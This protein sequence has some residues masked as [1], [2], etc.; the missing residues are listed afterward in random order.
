MK[1]LGISDG[2]TGGAALLE[3]G[4]ILY[5]I[6]EERLTRQKMA[7]GFPGE[8]IKR[9]LEDTGTKPEEIGAI[10]VATLNEFFRE[11]AIAYDGWLL[12]EQAPLKE[13]LLSTASVVNRIFGATP[14]LQ[15]SYYDL[16]SVMGRAR[17]KSI[18]SLLRRDWGFT[19]P[20]KFINHHYAHACSA[21]FTSGL[22]DATVI[23]MDGAGDDSSSH[24]YHVQ[25]GRLRRL[26]N[27]SSFD[28]IGNYYAYVTHICGFKAQKH[29]GKVTGLAA[30]G[31]PIYADLLKR[32]IAYENG[33]TVNKG[34]VFYWAA[35]KALE[36]ALPASWR[37]E[38]LASSMQ[39]VL[40][41]IGCAY[42]DRWVRKTGC[43]DLA[44]AGGVFANVKLNQRVH[45]LKSV[46]SV[47][48]HL[49]MGDEGLSLGAAF[50]LAG[51]GSWTAT[52]PTTLCDAYFGPGHG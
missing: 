32:F 47:F 25:D 45:E 20:I 6:H 18:E 23:T 26:H 27:I 15:Q 8:S 52:D 21:Y 9:A 44:L 34:R 46:R 19:A 42:I 24:V 43:G 28:S 36:K 49:G 35:V 48:I 10:G 29:E 50:G 41:E 13:A 4:R 31:E 5:A 38:D 22:G 1:T 51:A 7:T 12:R 33:G 16:K 37:R 40:E 3:D 14:F 30:Y 39:S 11:R 17:R 2:M